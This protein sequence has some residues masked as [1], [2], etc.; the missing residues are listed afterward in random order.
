MTRDQ[1]TG[2]PRST[3]LV[4]EVTRTVAHEGSWSGDDPTGSLV[5]GSSADTNGSDTRENPTWPRDARRVVHR[6]AVEGDDVVDLAMPWPWS[7]LV[8]QVASTRL[9][10]SD[11]APDDVD[12]TTLLLP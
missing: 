9:R 4:T 11:V 1:S 6:A 8:S 12:E 2:A 7:G 3:S 5:G 10:R